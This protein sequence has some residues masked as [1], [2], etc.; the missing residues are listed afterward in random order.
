MIQSVRLLDNR[1][2]RPG[3]Y[4]SMLLSE[5]LFICRSLVM[6]NKSLSGSKTCT[7]GS[8]RS[9]QRAIFLVRKELKYRRADKEFSRVR[10]AP[11]T[12]QIQSMEIFPA[13]LFSLSKCL[14][15]EF[16]ANTLNFPVKHVNKQTGDILLRKKHCSS[17][18]VD[19]LLLPF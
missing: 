8:D 17:P 12:P 14:C 15:T 11:K 6:S 9:T 3:S 18:L 2:E 10:F 16:K 13:F 5:H 1:I 4:A 19:A 7:L